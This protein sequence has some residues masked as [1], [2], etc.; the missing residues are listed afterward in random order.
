MI[1]DRIRTNI[2]PGTVIPKPEATADFTVK[3]WGRRRSKDALIYRIPNHSNPSKPSEKGRQPRSSP[4][5]MTSLERLAALLASGSTM[6]F[7]TVPRKED[8]TSP[9]SGAYLNC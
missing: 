3:G 2:K 7:V 1:I 5:P 6:R 9:P 4:L 8:A